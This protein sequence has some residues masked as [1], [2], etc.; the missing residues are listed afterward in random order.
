[1]LQDRAAR[2]RLD[3]LPLSFTTV[4]TAPAQNRVTALKIQI[5]NTSTNTNTNTL[6]HRLYL[7]DDD[8]VAQIWAW[9]TLHAALVKHHHYLPL[10]GHW[11]WKIYR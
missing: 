1:M 8:W 7:C 2:G 6:Q 10:F 11:S 5:T 4:A 3:T 9:G